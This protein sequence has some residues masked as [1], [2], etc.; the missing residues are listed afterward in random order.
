M[1]AIENVFSHLKMS[2]VAQDGQRQHLIYHV[3]LIDKVAETSD[4]NLIFFYFTVKH[5]AH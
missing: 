4:C 1:L 5:I 2:Y 3:S